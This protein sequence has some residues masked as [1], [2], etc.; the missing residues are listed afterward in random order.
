MEALRE[1]NPAL[2]EQIK[3][4]AV[5]SERERLSDIDALTVPG[6]EEMAEQA[7]ADGT[8]AMEFQKQF[9]AAMRKKGADFLK[10]RAEE[11]APAQQVAGGA[12]EDEEDEEQKVKAIA[13]SIAEYAKA[14]HGMTEGMF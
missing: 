5:E 3:Q 14:S 6:Y 9:V 7:K 10:A 8:S 4:E 13:E 11:T 2:I 12:A 1:G